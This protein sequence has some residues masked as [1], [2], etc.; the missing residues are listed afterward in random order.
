MS[1]ATASCTYVLDP[2]HPQS[3]GGEPGDACHVDEELLNEAGV[4]TCPHAAEA[5]ED[6][7]IFHL[8]V[9]EKDDADVVAAFLDAV[10]TA[11]DKT[12]SDAHRRAVEFLGAEFGT[13]DIGAASVTVPHATFTGANFRGDADFES[14]TFAGPA[15][16]SMV[17]FGG[18]AT[19]REAA[20]NDEAVFTASQFHAAATF[21]DAHFHTGGF[22]SATF[23][24][25][26]NFSGA[27][28]E[29]ATDFSDAVFAASVNFHASR[30]AERVDFGHVSFTE[31][32]FDASTFEAH[33]SLLNAT[34]QTEA[35]FRNCSFEDELFALRASLHSGEFFQT[36]FGDRVTFHEADF[37]GGT[38]RF[39]EFSREANFVGA[40]FDR[41]SFRDV[42]F[43]GQA[44]FRNARLES[45]DF[46]NA[47]F[48]NGV[49]FRELDLSSVIFSEANLTEADLM[50][51]DLRGVDMERS[52]LSRA[53]L[54]GADLRGAKLADTSLGDVRI[55]EETRF[56]GDPS[57]NSDVSPHTLAAIRS[58]HTCVYDPG[59]D[60]GAGETDVDTAKSV[61][62]ALEE[63]G[64][65]HA[66]PR[67]QARA[68][69]RRQDLQTQGYW[70]DA[71][72]AESIEERLIAG[73]RWS[74]A[75]IARVTLLYGE[76]P[77]RVIAWSLGI[78]L[79][80]A[81]LYP[82]GGWM[83]PAEGAPITYTQIVANPVELLNAVYYS[84]LTYTALGFGDFQP[85]G[86]GRL[87]TTVE[88]GLGAV[89]LALLV[90]ILGRRAA[91]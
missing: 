84:T 32:E 50:D 16:F 31:V 53:T 7:C 72:A 73:A 23:A 68:F 26:V 60:G 42:S 17:E 43:N 62:R 10:D 19:F 87:L 56:L 78:I 67:L 41:T 54:S 46:G 83:Q 24:D 30:F 65:Q 33:V 90:F 15:A 37:D 61:Y 75:K 47:E 49:D 21:E 34:I 91:R 63:L 13:F 36:T 18:K 88:T 66:R 11:T 38:F 80:F 39:A 5:Q 48:N 52:I 82:L 28:F 85:V 59:Y 86:L 57:D 29:T 2:E 58:R 1:Q 69:V 40:T 35:S 55:D 44:R 20:F 76:S 27:H 77:W 71:T 25:S 64:G 45:V 51:A 89:M 4:W 9:E 14:V 81:L 22:E 3:W 74:R 79:S 8:P 70:D 12:D 6:H